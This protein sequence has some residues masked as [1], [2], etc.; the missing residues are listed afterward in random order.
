MNC[1]GC[2]ALI[3]KM[4]EGKPIISVITCAHNEERYVGKCLASVRRALRNFESEIVFVADCCNDNTVEIA[5]KYNVEKLIVK[6]WKS[7]KNSYAEAL[8]TGFL[9]SSGK[10]VNIL[11][12]D[13]VIPN[14]FFEKMLPIVK[15]KTVSVSASVETYPS[16]LFNSLY[17][18]WERTHE[19]TPFGKEPRGAARIMLR[20]VLEEVGGFSDVL[21]PDTDLD[22]KV[23]ERG[24]RS[25]YFKDVKVWHIREIN[26]EK[27]VAGQL[28]S[29][30]ARYNLGVSFMRTLG[31]SIFR[32]RPFVTCGWIIEWLRE[33]FM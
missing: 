32:A 31:H 24:Y 10:Y 28:G 12:A 21:A 20:E 19:L 25:V 9:Q 11:D 29:G 4:A 3:G 13:I 26:F 1:K 14:D 18:A 15:G 33:E 27:V 7:W 30:A 2:G 22:V 23:R 5:K 6:N 17:Y 16:T 8:Q